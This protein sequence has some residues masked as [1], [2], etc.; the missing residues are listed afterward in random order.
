[1]ALA[2]VPQPVEQHARLGNGQ[3]G[4]A[5]FA[6]ALAVGT[7]WFDL[8]AELLR[9]HLLAVADAENGRPLSHID[10]GA[11]GLPRART[12]AGE[13]ERTTPLGSLRLH[14][15]PAARDGDDRTESGNRW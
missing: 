2:D 3:K 15:A 9:H 7:A 8:Y 10:C 1:M 11:P 13:P 4:A 6:V 12:A 5:E 14:S